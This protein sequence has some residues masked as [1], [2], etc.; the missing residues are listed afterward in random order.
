MAVISLLDIRLKEFLEA[1]E[2]RAGIKLPRRVVSV[3]LA[4]G[5]LHVRFAYPKTMETDVEPLPLKTP[6]FL[7]RDEETGEITALEIIDIEEALAE[8]G[9]EGAST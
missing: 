6:A 2:K 7:F 9:A 8:L 5:V 4:E 3:S 1:L